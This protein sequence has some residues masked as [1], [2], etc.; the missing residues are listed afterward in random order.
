LEKNLIVFLRVKKN[1]KL[2]LLKSNLKITLNEN[3][4]KNKPKI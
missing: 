2:K 3:F 1:E 4:L